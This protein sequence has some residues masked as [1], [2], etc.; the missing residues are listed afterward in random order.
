MRHVAGLTELRILELRDLA[1]GDAG[2]K[3]I[4]SLKKLETLEMENVAITDDAVAT[5]IALSSLR[6]LWVVGTVVTDDGLR[7]LQAA[8][9]RSLCVGPGAATE[10]L[11]ELRSLMPDCRINDR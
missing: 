3:A 10:L 9:L 2:I 5:L 7:Q 4:G 1:I 11:D 6:R 8:Y